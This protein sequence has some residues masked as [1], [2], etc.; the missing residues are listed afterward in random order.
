MNLLSKIVGQK[1]VE[2]Y[3]RYKEQQVHCSFFRLFML[4]PEFRYQFYYRLRHHSKV[5]KILLTPLQLINVHNL[6]IYCSDIGE[7]L[8]I[9]H[10]FA[11]VINCKHIGKNCLINQQVTIGFNDT[12]SPYI[13]DNVLIRAGAKVIGGITIGDD[14]HI[15]AGAVVVHDVP[16]HSVVAGVPAKVIKT[17]KQIGDTWERVK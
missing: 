8:F 15:A 16:S 13:G 12:H 10:G 6:Y 17:R 14:V 5:W 7:G 9:Q 1:W 3:K 11:T 4:C 2:D